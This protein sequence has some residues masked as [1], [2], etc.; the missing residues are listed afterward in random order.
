MQIV[1]CPGIHPPALTEHF[2]KALPNRSTQMLIVP[3]DQ[4]PYSGAHIL[5]FVL[6]QLSSASPS[7]SAECRHQTALQTPLFLIG[8]SAGVVGAITCAYLWQGLGGKVLALIAFDGW[9]VPLF[10]PF[11]IHRISHDAF[12]HWSS[13]LLGA[14]Q[15]SFYADPAVAHLDLWS[16][17]QHAQGWSMQQSSTS[18]TTAITFLD[19]LIQHYQ[20]K[21]IK[22]LMRI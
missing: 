8:F 3:V 12:T 5:A 18:R 4:P 15:E 11:P 9:G 6:Q 14:G 10:A 21:E 22:D 17:P 13:A 7:N 16:F 1:I 20:D 19:Q 2:V